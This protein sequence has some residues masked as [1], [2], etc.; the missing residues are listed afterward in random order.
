M[1]DLELETLFYKLWDRFDIAGTLVVHVPR[2]HCDYMNTS[3]GPSSQ[4]NEAVWDW[5]KDRG[6]RRGCWRPG[7][8][9]DNW[10]QYEDED[11][12]VTVR[13]HITD[14]KIARW[15]KLTWC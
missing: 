12:R 15:F 3:N 11:R 6:L 8:C 13:F 2:E 5:L 10:P 14:F 4:P 1:T 7:Y 9:V